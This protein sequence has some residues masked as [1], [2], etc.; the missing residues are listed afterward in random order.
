MVEATPF[1]EGEN[2]SLEM[3]ERKGLAQV[4]IGSLFETPQTFSNFVALA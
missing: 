4:H 3:L 2:L 1:L